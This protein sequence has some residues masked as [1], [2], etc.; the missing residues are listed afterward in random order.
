M[1]TDGLAFVMVE[2]VDADGHVV[3][4]ADNEL[5]FSVSG[6][7][8]LLAAGNGNVKD[9]DPYFDAR[10]HVWQGRALAVLRHNG[11]KKAATLT[12]TAHGLPTARL[13]IVSDTHGN[14]R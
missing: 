4:S 3:P 6:G 5:T 11:Q 14:K 7:A 2:I 10:H 12:V 9:E 13:V 1:K 8:V